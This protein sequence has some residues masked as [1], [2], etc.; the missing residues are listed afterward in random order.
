M[1]KSE[2]QSERAGEIVRCGVL[3]IARSDTVRE[4]VGCKKEGVNGRTPK[5]ESFCEKRK[6]D[7]FKRR[8]KGRRQMKRHESEGLGGT[9]MGLQ[10]LTETLGHS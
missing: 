9:M 3:K 6:K 7:L 10:D 1:Q 5:R 4:R 2:R 8:N